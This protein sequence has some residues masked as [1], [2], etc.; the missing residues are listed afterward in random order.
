MPYTLQRKTERIVFSCLKLDSD[1]LLVVIA[2]WNQQH[3]PTSKLT[4]FSKKQIQG[5]KDIFLYDE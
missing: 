5:H 4:L 3:I 1:N 2:L